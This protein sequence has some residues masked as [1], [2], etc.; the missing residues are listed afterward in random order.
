VLNTK[1]GVAKTSTAFALA[2]SLTLRGLEIL[3]LDADPQA[4]ATTLTGTVPERDIGWDQTIGPF[5]FGDQPD[6]TYA[7]QTT[8]WD[9]L[10]LIP[11]SALAYD[12]EMHI[13]ARSAQGRARLWDFFVRGLAPLK[14]H[15]DAIIIDTSPALGNLTINAVFAADGLLVPSPP[16]AI[17]F[18]AGAQFW[19]L[20]GGLLEA[21]GERVGAELKDKRW[22]F[23]YVLPTLA[24][25][26]SQSYQLVR[27]WMAEA[28]GNKMFPGEI[29]SSKVA[30]TLS[31]EFCTVYDVGGRYG[32]NAQSYR[33]LRD[34]YDRLGEVMD[35]TLVNVRAAQ[36]RAEA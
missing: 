16:N 2:Q 31:A 6:L 26:S 17:D 30:Q 19:T 4:S 35:M 15:Y 14:K 20:F 33:R 5:V 27:E 13:W 24:D 7:V 11:S 32:G 21:L 1:G 9:G 28:Y 12:S 10:D 22:H 25:P 34:G 23:A 36:R 29:L 18:A 3:V 8:Y